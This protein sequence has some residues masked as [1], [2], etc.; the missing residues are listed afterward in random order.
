MKFRIVSRTS[1]SPNTMLVYRADEFSFD[2]EPASVAGLTSILVND[3]NLEV[4]DVGRVISVWGLCPY[5]QWKPASLKE[6][7]ADPGEAFVV[8]EAPLRRGVSIRI[9]QQSRW[10]TCADATSGWICM[11]GKNA[12]D[13]ATKILSGIILETNHSGDLCSIWLKPEHFPRMWNNNAQ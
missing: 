6:P 9:N 10:D 4:D 12:P 1:G 5:E 8:S 3:L 7:V 2:T 11:K 13:S